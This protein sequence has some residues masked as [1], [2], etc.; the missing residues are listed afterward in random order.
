M[1]RFIF[2]HFKYYIIPFYIK[3]IYIISWT[4]STFYISIDLQE[5]WSKFVIS[6]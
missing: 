5:F 4:F 1:T 2:K 6:I 3:I